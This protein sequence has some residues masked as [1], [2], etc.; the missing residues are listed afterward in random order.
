MGIYSAVRVVERYPDIK[1]RP[2]LGVI[3]YRAM[4]II[5]SHRVSISQTIRINRFIEEKREYANG[6]VLYLSQLRDPQKRCINT[7]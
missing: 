2:Q 5:Y 4:K 1:T 3:L 7:P 6:H